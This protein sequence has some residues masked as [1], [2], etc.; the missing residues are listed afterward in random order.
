MEKEK[1]GVSIICSSQNDFATYREH[2]LKMCGV[3]N[4]EFLGYT[5]KGE[6]GLSE[7]Y[8]KGLKEAKNDIIIF[9]HHD[10]I[11]EPGFG[12][13][14]LTHFRKTD[15][16]ILGLAGTTHIGD[17]GQWWA[18]STKM[19]GIV[20]H[21]QIVDNPQYTPQN[22]EP[23][24]VK[25][26]W[27]SR[28][29]NNFG[30]E[31]IKTVMI[32]GLFMAVD[33]TKIKVNFNEELKWHFYDMYFSFYNHLDGVKVGV[34]FDVKVT[35]LS[36][37]QTNEEWEENRKTFAEAFKKEL[38]YNITPEIKYDDKPVKIKSEPKV[39][40]II[41]TKGKLDLL[42]QAIDSIYDKSAYNNM[43]ILIADTGSSNEEKADI[44]DYILNY[45]VLSDRVYDIKLIEYDY[46]NFGKINN[47]VVR[48]H[49]S[50]DSELLLFCNND[51]KL[52]ND[53]IS[54]MVKE[55]LS[56]KNVGTIG[57]RLHFEDGSIQHS[58]VVLMSPDGKELKI[59][60]YGLKSYY[61]YHNYKGDILG[62]TGA[63]MMTS[64][65]LF[66]EIGGYN[67][68]YTECFEDVEYNIECI[69]RGRKNI[70]LGNAVAHHYE[71]QTRNDD[72]KQ[73]ERIMDDWDNRLIH[74][75]KANQ[76][77]IKYVNK[78]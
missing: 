21:Q 23:E 14:V 48:N 51:I 25:R 70:F 5:N 47:D 29:S 68:E 64:K 62:N 78:F 15:Y 72:P 28:Y 9:I 8:N 61:S 38:P 10:L 42:F 65:R 46:Y 49:V 20:K 4:V 7:I 52:L 60:H 27:E 67:E 2:V 58:G 54:L 24:K 31:I 1:N 73:L 30:K 77:I 44:E 57:A 34:I 39:S 53:V 17:S 18:D 32:D 56:N 22:G 71:S 69:L 16:G 41:P 40:I 19:V 45:Q 26:T 74:K 66:N 75:I 11:L 35:H 6:F 50:A 3:S 12:K 36:I 43:E 55:Y 63:L 59:T 33:R 37:G 76:D 13:K